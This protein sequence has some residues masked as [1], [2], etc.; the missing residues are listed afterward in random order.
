MGILLPAQKTGQE[1]GIVLIVHLGK[2]NILFMSR[3]MG[4]AG[5]YGMDDTSI[6]KCCC[7]QGPCTCG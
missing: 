7:N 3:I 1:F 6:I 4:Q 2:D 5:L